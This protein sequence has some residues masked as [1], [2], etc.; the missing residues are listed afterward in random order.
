MGDQGIE[1]ITFV[2]DPDLSATARHHLTRKINRSKSDSWIAAAIIG[3]LLSIISPFLL[4]ILHF[5]IGLSWW[6]MLAI[7]VPAV[8]GFSVAA[9]LDDQPDSRDRSGYI[10]PTTLGKPERELL[11]RAQQAITAAL[12]SGVH[13]DNLVE[14]TVT[15]KILRRHEWEIATNL[16]DIHKLSVELE[17]STRAGT[18]GPRTTA[19]LRSQRH[20]LTVAT[21]ATVSRIKALERY[22]EQLWAADAA[23]RDWE[24]A[25]RASGRNDL[26]LDIVARTAADQHAI[27]E[28]AG[29]T[30]AAAAAQAF[31]DSLHQANLAAEAL[32]LPPRQPESKAPGSD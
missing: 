32:V 18:P 21:E 24:Y 19:V 14:H 29:L 16:R 26:Y 22:A 10:D 8:V 31:Q 9:V 27:A 5:A 25:V 30:E 28:I 1:R 17:Q 7:P 20:A 11:L 4:L 23:K 6:W 12:K 15:D 13:A 3:L 2:F